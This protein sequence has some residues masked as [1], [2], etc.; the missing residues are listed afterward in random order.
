M[1]SQGATLFGKFRKLGR[2]FLTLDGAPKGDYS[3]CT[4]KNLPAFPKSDGGSPAPVVISGSKMDFIYAL[5]FNNGGG[6]TLS[7]GVHI[8]G[9]ANV[10]CD[11]A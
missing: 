9:D 1:P 5:F 8:T 6:Y 7:G 10:S 11:F 4:F 3:N 2:T